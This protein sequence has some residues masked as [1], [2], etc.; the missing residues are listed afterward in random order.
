M[1][2]DFCSQKAL[3]K[4]PAKITV[5]D[6]DQY[7]EE[8]GLAKPA[9]YSP[10][11]DEMALSPDIQAALPL[12]LHELAHHF[13]AARDGAEEFDRKYD[14]YLE[15]HGYENNPYE[16]GAR[17]FARKWWPDFERLLKERLEEK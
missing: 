11:K 15:K 1:I 13:Q 16:I 12:I 4:P 5:Y 10:T 3:G 2:T 17:E 7:T 8:T 6:W 14:E 9:S